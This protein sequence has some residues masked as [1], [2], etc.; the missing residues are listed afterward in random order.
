[1]K[2]SVVPDDHLHNKYRSITNLYRQQ[3]PQNVRWKDSRTAH[4]HNARESLNKLSAIFFFLM[5]VRPIP[6]N[7]VIH[8]AIRR[9]LMRAHSFDIWWAIPLQFPMSWQSTFVTSSVSPLDQLLCHAKLCGSTSD[10]ITNIVTYGK[11][12][13]KNSQTARSICVRTHH[14]LPLWAG[15]C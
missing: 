10:S 4:H 1:M 13:L 3:D 5:Y 11:G 12:T 2:L 14:I 9:A 15:E 7:S 6:V 8:I